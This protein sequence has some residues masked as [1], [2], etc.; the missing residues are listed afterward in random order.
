MNMI[1]VGALTIVAFSGMLAFFRGFV[2]EVLGIAAW[3]GAGLF[4]MSTFYFVQGRFR[5]LIQ[6]PDV[7]DPVAFACLFVASLIAFSILAST[8]GSLA[9]VS[10]VG[11]IDKTLG[12][13]FGF[14][15]GAALIAFAYI[16]LGLLS[17]PDKWPEQV[18]Q[19]RLLPAA[20]VGAAWG[21][22]LLPG[23][24]RPRIY[25]PPGG[26]EATSADLLR[27]EPKGRAFGQRP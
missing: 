26:R 12:M 22:N 1:D 16:A 3:V 13:L 2:R 5:M 8:L 18:A 23:D 21:L 17:P 20:Y 6:N 11:G 25:P 4:A 10:M 9:R 14:L 27:V 19:A 24:Y 15:R 7:A